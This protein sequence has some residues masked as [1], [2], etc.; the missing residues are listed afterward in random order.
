MIPII[1]I[2]IR[3]SISVKPL[4]R[5]YLL[6]FGIAAVVVS[7]SQVETRQLL[8]DSLQEKRA[9]V[10]DKNK[11]F[12]FL[13]DRMNPEDL[14]P[15]L[16]AKFDGSAVFDCYLK[17]VGVTEASYIQRYVEECNKQ[18]RLDQIFQKELISRILLE[19]TVASAS[20]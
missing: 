3:S 2:T 8:F 7:K 20:A 4:P 16:L 12:D 1:A 5:D 17:K 10:L 19:V 11:H 18:G 6:D 13:F 15:S 14:S 9:K